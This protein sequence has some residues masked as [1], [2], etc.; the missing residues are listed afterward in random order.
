LILN[1]DKA[2]ALP[3][4]VV[5]VSYREPG[6]MS[7]SQYLISLLTITLGCLL[8]LGLTIIQESKKIH[9]KI[10]IITFFILNVDELE[11]KNL[12]HKSK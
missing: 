1:S 4:V 7:L 8:C 12:N 9:N 2:N 10:N 11:I 3:N 5:F 6:N